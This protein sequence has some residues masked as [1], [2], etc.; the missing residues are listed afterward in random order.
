MSLIKGEETPTQ[1]FE[2]LPRISLEF[3]ESVGGDEVPDDI[4]ELIIAAIAHG[5]YCA[6]NA[7]LHGYDTEENKIEPVTLISVIE[8]AESL[9]EAFFEDD[10]DVGEDNEED[11]RQVDDPEDTDD[12]DSSEELNK[13]SEVKDAQT[14]IED[15]MKPKQDT[16]LRSDWVNVNKLTNGKKAN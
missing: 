5:A 11:T 12:Q 14:K 9:L 8:E 16:G 1:G 10:D 3:I 2:L 15:Q 4:K 6:L 7:V 13:H